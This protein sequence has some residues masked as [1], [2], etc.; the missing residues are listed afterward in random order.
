[1]AICGKGMETQ[2]KRKIY[3]SEYLTGQNVKLFTDA[4]YSVIDLEIKNRSF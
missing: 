2:L 3:Q 4:K 1:M